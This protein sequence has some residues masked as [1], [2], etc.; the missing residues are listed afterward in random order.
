M[1]DHDRRDD[2][3]GERVVGAAGLRVDERHLDVAVEAD[4]AHRDQLDV[5]IGPHRA[6]LGATDDAA[7]RDE[8]FLLEKPMGEV[9][10][11]HRA[12]HGIGIGVVVRQDDERTGPLEHAE[13]LREQAA[14]RGAGHEGR[15]IM[16]P[17]PRGCP[18]R[19]FRVSARMASGTA[20]ASRQA[21]RPGVAPTSRRRVL[22]RLARSRA[23]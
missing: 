11:R 4:L 9:L 2:A 10:E 22:S 12:R 20:P 21:L 13:E 1:V 3:V 15:P 7:E 18:S 16:T 6:V 14:R 5:E 23:V 17:A 8:G 19:R